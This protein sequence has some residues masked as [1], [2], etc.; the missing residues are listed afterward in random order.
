MI[1]LLYV[2]QLV[3]DNV[4]DNFLRHQHYQTVKIKVALCSAAAVARFLISDCNF[5]VFYT[6]FVGV[7]TAVIDEAQEKMN[8]KTDPEFKKAILNSKGLCLP[9]TALLLEAAA[10]HAIK[11]DTRQSGYFTSFIVNHCY[12]N[13]EGSSKNYTENDSALLLNELKKSRY[14][15]FEDY[16]QMKTIKEKLEKY[17][18]Y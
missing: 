7:V 3:N 13:V 4:I 11:Y 15:R 10:E 16:V 1:H 14:D 9:D 8:L 6:D 5:S 18:Q 17:A 12:D 2:T